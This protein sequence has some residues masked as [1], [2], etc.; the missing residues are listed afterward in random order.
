LQPA[1]APRYSATRSAPP[2]AA[3]RAGAETDLVLGELGY[4]AGGIA[5]LRAA[6]ILG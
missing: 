3:S 5:K 6:G 4:D 1:P 2:I